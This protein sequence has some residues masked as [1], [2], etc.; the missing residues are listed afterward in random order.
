MSDDEPPPL[1]EAEEEVED[2]RTPQERAAAKKLE[3]NER[4]K[5]G[6]YSEAVKLY[7]GK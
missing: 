2:T 4:F 7:S 3:G 6:R 5:S 1:Q